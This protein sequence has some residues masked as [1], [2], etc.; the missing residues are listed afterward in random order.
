[1]KYNKQDVTAIGV[2]ALV[3]F[4][5]SFLYSDVNIERRL[6]ICVLFGLFL[7]IGKGFANGWLNRDIGRTRE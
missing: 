5:L 3:V 1:M 4:A 7:L 2:S 6:L